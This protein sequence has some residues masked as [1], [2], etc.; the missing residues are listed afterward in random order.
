MLI[1]AIPGR[2]ALNIHHLVL[3]YNG[4]LARDG[5]LIEG[6]APLLERLAGRL[7]IHVVTGDTFGK[8]RAALAQLPC[9]T[10]ILEPNGQATAKLEH[11]ARLGASKTVCIGNGRNDRLML[12][13]AG[14]GIAVVQAEGASAETL[15]AADIVTGNIHDAL[16]LLLHPLRIAATLRD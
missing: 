5:V 3:D 6:V 16:E 8:A 11:L 13:A 12:Q 7:Q 10:V 14:L 15:Q 4:T 2:E 9:E 1:I